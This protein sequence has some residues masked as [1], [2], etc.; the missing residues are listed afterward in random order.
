MDPDERKRFVGHL[1]S[2]MAVSLGWTVVPETGQVSSGLRTVGRLEPRS[3][4]NPPRTRAEEV[5]CLTKPV[6]SV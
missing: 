3:V 5:V 6:G 1:K 2:P 4:K